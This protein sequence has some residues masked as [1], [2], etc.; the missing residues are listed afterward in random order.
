M[1]YAASV[2]VAGYAQYVAK[3]VEELKDAPSNSSSSSS[4]SSSSDEEE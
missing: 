3:K 1:D 2:D 4:S